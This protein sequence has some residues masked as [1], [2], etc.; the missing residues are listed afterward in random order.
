MYLYDEIGGTGKIIGNGI[1]LGNNVVLTNQSS[2]IDRDGKYDLNLTSAV[3][4]PTIYHDIEVVVRKDLYF[5]EFYYSEQTVQVSTVKDESITYTF[6]F[7]QDALDDINFETCEFILKLTYPYQESYYDETKKVGYAYIPTLG[8][9][10]T[11]IFSTLV[12]DSMG[13]RTNTDISINKITNYGITL[14]VKTTYFSSGY[15]TFP[16]TVQLFYRNRV[17]AVAE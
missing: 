2:Y 15:T 12:E 9:I 16:I 8:Q 5:Y 7:N 3:T 17:L 14:S 6:S 1:Q 11:T 4:I 10:P 13:K